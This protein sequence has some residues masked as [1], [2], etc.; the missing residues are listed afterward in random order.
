MEFKSVDNYIMSKIE[1]CETLE[2]RERR[3]ERR[4]NRLGCEKS[5]ERPPRVL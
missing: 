3:I 4:R 1:K 2:K 5:E